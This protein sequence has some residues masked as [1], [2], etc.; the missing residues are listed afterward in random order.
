[1][2]NFVG[3][4]QERASRRRLRRYCAR[5][6]LAHLDELR[7][8]HA[9]HRDLEDGPTRANPIRRERVM[10]GCEARRKSVD[11]LDIARRSQVVDDR[12]A[13][14]HRL[15]GV[16]GHKVAITLL[17]GAQGAPEKALVVASGAA[18]TDIPVDHPDIFPQPAEPVLGD[19]PN[20]EIRELLRRRDP[21]GGFQDV[22]SVMWVEPADRVAE[23]DNETGDFRI[24]GS[25]RS[26]K[27][28]T[29][30]RVSQ[31]YPQD[32]L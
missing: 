28:D 16:G 2:Q 25:I 5:Y 20:R 11:E 9:R 6:L 30:V 17:I 29:P 24:S 26:S 23:P 19:G 22:A 3:Q 15:Q 31:R 13:A 21:N 27:H 7:Q 12:L 18:T 10:L 32:C 8:P 4:P 1:M 14:I